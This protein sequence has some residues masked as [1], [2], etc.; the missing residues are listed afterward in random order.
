MMTSDEDYDSADEALCEMLGISSKV[1]K[2]PINDEN[3][4]EVCHS[5]YT[6]NDYITPS[7]LQI[8]K[9]IHDNS[10]KF[11]YAKD[12][13]SI[14]P[15][16]LSIDKKLLMRLTDE[17]TYGSNKFQSDKSFEKILYLRNGTVEEKRVL[18]RFENFVNYHSE[19]K[20]ITDYVAVCCSI[21][22]GE[23]MVLFKEKLNLK[24]PGGNGFAPHLD[25]PSLSV[26]LGD[27]GPKDF[28]T[29][30]I[31]IDDMNENNGCLKVCK[32][33]W[34]E[35]FH[36]EVITPESDDD[37]PDAG[38]RRGAI[39]LH[40]ANDLKFD[41]IICRGGNIVCFNGWIPHR[42]S[43][44]TSPFPRRAIFLTY[45]PS[46]EGDYHGLYYSR[47]TALRD[48]YRKKV[49]YHAMNDYDAEIAAMKTIP[50]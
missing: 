41:P 6:E 42:S 40:I 34:S 48:E 19:W 32:G 38:G 10:C 27:A 18:T 2:Q 16:E 39:P 44:N 25:G 20:Q 4:E 36:I 11:M 30:M 21:L 12:S 49:E 37:D 8:R 23:E 7:E 24:P 31:A 26:A 33:A 47:M 14:L 9:I 13:I 46:R 22:T 17:L 28:L 3:V 15:S 45:N 50:S 35:E 5:I 1:I 29:V 43:A